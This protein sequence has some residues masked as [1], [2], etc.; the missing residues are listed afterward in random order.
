[1]RGLSARELSRRLTPAVPLAWLRNAGDPIEHAPEERMQNPRG[2]TVGMGRGN[3]LP[4]L[5]NG[6]TWAPSPRGTGGWSGTRFPPPWD[7]AVP[8]CSLG[9]ELRRFRM[10]FPPQSGD[11][12]HP[13]R[14]STCVAH[15]ISIEEKKKKKKPKR[16][17]PR[18]KGSCVLLMSR[19][20]CQ[21]DVGA[22]K[23]QP[24]EAPRKDA[25]NSVGGEDGAAVKPPR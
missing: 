24:S 21:R 11:T 8:E 10:L 20:R 15:L 1:M 2:F 5:R 25:S 17:Q 7:A 18:A 4:D 3:L 13:C 6:K 14:F 22:G 12:S 16:L 19:L 9:T 23:E